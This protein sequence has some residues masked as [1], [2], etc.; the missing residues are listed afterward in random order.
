MIEGT[1]PANWRLYRGE[2][3]TWLQYHREDGMVFTYLIVGNDFNASLEPNSYF[4]Q[5][6]SGV[7]EVNQREDSKVVDSKVI[8]LRNPQHRKQVSE[9]YEDMRSGFSAYECE[10]FCRDVL[11]N[12]MDSH[13]YIDCGLLHGPVGAVSTDPAGVHISHEFQNGITGRRLLVQLSFTE[14]EAA[15]EHG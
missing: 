1:K 8:D 4:V 11:A 9:A 2:V 10:R 15:G 13:G 7:Q 3:S 14:T 5:G 6:A 12:Y